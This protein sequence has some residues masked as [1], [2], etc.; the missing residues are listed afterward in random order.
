MRKQ[1]EHD[2]F[3]SVFINYNIKG[4]KPLHIAIYKASID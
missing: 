2:D 1:T 3:K 4:G